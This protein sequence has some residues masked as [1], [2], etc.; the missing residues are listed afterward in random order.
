[1][2]SGPNPIIRVALFLLIPLLTTFLRAQLLPPEA[3]LLTREGQA[4]LDRNEFALAVQDL[5]RARR[6]APHIP[7]ILRPLL[8]SYLQ[9]SQLNEAVEVGR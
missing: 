3:E 4:A 5:E 7:R 9:A 2:S 1:M 6:V 8:L